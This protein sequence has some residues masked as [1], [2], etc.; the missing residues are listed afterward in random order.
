VPGTVLVTDQ[1]FGRLDTERA[2]LAEIGYE[3]REAPDADEATL[4]ELAGEAAGMLVCYAQIGAR[5]VEAAGQCRVISRYGVG[6]DNVDVDAA[7][8]AGILVTYVPDYCLDEVADHTLALILAASR[9]LLRATLDVRSG[10]WTIP[11]A[12]IRRLQGRRLALIGVGRIG[13]RVAHRAL[14][15]GLEVVGYDPVASDWSSEPGLR[16]A[17]TLEDALAEADIVSLHAP[18][19]PENRHLIGEDTIALMRRAPLVVNTSRGGLVDLDA[20]AQALADGRLSGLALDVTEVEPL[21]ADHPLRTDPRA[22]VTPHM[23]LYSAEALDEL[24]RRAAD[25]VVRAL[26]GVSPRCPVNPEVLS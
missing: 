19:T 20:A 2:A 3:L 18:L 10:E 24:Q 7:T 13:L 6:V 26:T 11:K 9:N 15:F 21:P 14:A 12:G 25:E 4:V 1:V 5:V 17:P 16:R 22:L 23:A 8:R